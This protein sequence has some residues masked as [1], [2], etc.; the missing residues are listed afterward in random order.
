MQSNYIHDVIQ[1]EQTEQQQSKIKESGRVFYRKK[2]IITTKN[3][4]NIELI[5][6]NDKPI[7][8]LQ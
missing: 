5:L 1:I 2:I 6:I 4:N 7:T 8:E 3:N